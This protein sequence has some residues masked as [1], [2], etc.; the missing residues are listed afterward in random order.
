MR[1][2]VLNEDGER[3]GTITDDPF[4][5]SNRDGVGEDIS[6]VFAGVKGAT[7]AVADSP[8]V[9]PEQLAAERFDAE[10]LSRRR[11]LIRNAARANG[12]GLV[13]ATEFQ[14]ANATRYSEGDEVSTPQGVGVVADVLTET[15]ETDED[16]IEAD[17]SSPTYVVVVEDGRVGYETYK[18]EDIHSTTIET[19][20]DDP[21]AAMADEEE[22]ANA[23]GRVIDLLTPS[24]SAN[25]FD[26]PP[27]WRKSST[28]NRVIALKA[29]ASMNADFDKCTREMSGEVASPDRYCGAFF[30]YAIG[31]PY[32][33]GDS[34]LPGD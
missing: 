29:L 4:D 17:D 6:G 10:S 30:D 3:I 24:L 19:D 23:L 31:N 9:N 14:S 12:Y 21:E 7:D 22:T 15:V 25:D 28:P 11:Q 13:P 2:A 8:P 5:V 16:T 27:S 20:V 34:I 26:V 18:A 33:R 32:W 1:L